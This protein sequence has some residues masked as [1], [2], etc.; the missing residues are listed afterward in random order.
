[1]T[2]GTA[3]GEVMDKLCAETSTEDTGGVADN[4][5]GEV[6]HAGLVCA[7]IITSGSLG[8]GS[9][10]VAALGGRSDMK[11]EYAKLSH[12]QRMQSE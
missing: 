11:T 10:S 4:P 5:A 1:M 12:S 8:V 3:D 9:G 2:D 7:K 6:E